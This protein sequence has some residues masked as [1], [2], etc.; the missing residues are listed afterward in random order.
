MPKKIKIAYIL[1]PI[2]FGGSE[3][4]SLNF[5]KSVDREKFDINP[6]IFLRPWEA[7]PYF[8][9]ELRK[10]GYC[11]SVLPI[12]L[13][14]AGD[15]LR[16]IRCFSRVYSALKNGFFDLVHT[17]GYQADLVGISFVSLARDTPYGLVP[18]FYIN[19]Q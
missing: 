16:P 7:E 9:T 1:T 17:H 3:R 4:V 6:I 19:R 2:T 10:I 12:A 14:E 13:K 18:W 15:F 5:L 8:T 11:Y